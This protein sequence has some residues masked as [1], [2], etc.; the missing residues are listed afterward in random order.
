MSN[1]NKK[2]IMIG[3][4]ARKGGEGKS[5]GAV[6]IAGELVSRGNRVLLIVCD[7]QED[8]AN[9]YL[10]EQPGSVKLYE[11]DNHVSLSDVLTGQASIKDAI[12]QTREYPLYSWEYDSKGRPRMDLRGRRKRKRLFGQTIHLDII[13]AGSQIYDIDV[14]LEENDEGEVKPRYHLFEEVLED[15]ADLYDYVI[16]DIPPSDQNISMCAYAASDYLLTPYTGIDSPKSVEMMA[17]TVEMLNSIPDVGHRIELLI[18]VN[19]HYANSSLNEALLDSANAA[20]S[21]I[22]IKHPIRYSR[23]AEYAKADGVPLCCYPKT[24]VGE[25]VSFMADEL[26][27]RIRE[28]QGR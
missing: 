28:R 18:Y 17:D 3:F 22:M 19:K 14:Y 5:F 24:N 20:F 16:F 10:I 25:D 9:R 27:E 15:V 23:E 21:D 12:Y 6:N 7:Q 26:L 11:E 13:A 2:P 4:G 1:S 8:V